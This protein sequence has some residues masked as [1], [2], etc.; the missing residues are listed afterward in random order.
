MAFVCRHFEN[1]DK[2]FATAGAPLTEPRRGDFLCAISQM[3]AFGRHWKNGNTLQSPKAPLT[4]W[5]RLT[6]RHF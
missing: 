6:G 4:K 2:I 5:Q 1:G 3:A